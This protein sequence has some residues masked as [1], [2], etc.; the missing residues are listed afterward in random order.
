MP[1]CLTV[2]QQANTQTAAADVMTQH[3]FIDDIGYKGSSSQ[4]NIERLSVITMGS[5]KVDT[6]WK[7]IAC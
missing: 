5:H 6:S 3:F 1:V 7:T 2:Q 4:I